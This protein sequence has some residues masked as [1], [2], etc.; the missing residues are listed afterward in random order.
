[1]SDATKTPAA[2]K[3]KSRLPVILGLAGALAAGGGASYF[4]LGRGEAATAHAEAP[5][6]GI[7]AFEP[8]V[9]NLADASISR[10]LRVTLQLVVRT[11]EEA[12][13]LEESKVAMAQAR[14]TILEL[15]AVQK[16][17]SLVTADGKAALR[18]AIV[19]GVSHAIA[20]FEVVDVLFSDFVVQF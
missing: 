20:P 2:A 6:R 9:V 7:V 12:T 15:L 18:T 8:F 1:M 14:S 17:D 13:R 10:Y 16:S 4:F 5:A 3:S 19:E 11:E